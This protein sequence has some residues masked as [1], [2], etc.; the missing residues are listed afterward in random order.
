MTEEDNGLQ[1]VP[2]FW[3][4]V[5]TDPN[6]SAQQFWDDFYAQHTGGEHSA[7]GSWLVA[8]VGALEPGTALDLGCGEGSDALWLADHGWSVLGVDVSATA[9]GRA[10][11]S[12]ARL[13]QPGRVRF[14]QHDLASSFPEGTYG[15]VSA[16]FLHSPVAVPGEREG[17]LGRAA[18]AV[19]PGGHLL[20]VSH[21]GM[22]S[23]MDEPPAEL[24]LP[25]PEETL[26]ALC[27]TPG[28]WEI[29]T[30]ATVV[31]DV[32]GPEGQPGIRSDHVLHLRRVRDRASGDSANGAG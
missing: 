12:A 3:D 23:W 28:G 24:T 2:G 20:V 4:E 15:L 22:P 11:E 1:P 19:A 14:E 25:T 30:S 13:A 16:Q 26:A 32:P 9:V 10:G 27:L 8:E 31:S 5:R 6:R 21:Q 18:R 7:V 17:I 29:V